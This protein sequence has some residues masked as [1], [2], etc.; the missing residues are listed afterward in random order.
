[1][2]YRVGID[3]GGTFTD[4]ALLKGNEVILHKNLSTPEDRS[5][6]VMEG[7]G[8]LAGKEGLE[9]GQFLGKCEAIVHGTTVADNTLIEM[10]G[11]LT[12]LITTE[13]FR[14]E[15]EY[16][17]GYKED[18]WDVRLA[19]PKQITPRRRRL[20][21]PERILHDGTVH[22]PLDED[23]LR[24]A[25]RKLRLQ[26]VEA[27]AISFLFSFVNPEHERRAKEIVTQEIQNAYISAS[28]E[29][30]PRAPEYDRTSTTVVNAYVGPRVTGYLE[31]LVQR[32]VEG[33][34]QNQLMVM[35]ASGGVMT[36]EYIDG[37]PIRVLA[38]GPAGGVIGSAHTGTAKGCPDLLC[39]DMGGTSYDMSLVVGGQAP[40]EAGWNMHHRYLIG[41]PMVKVETLGAGGG[42][43]CHVNAG[44]LEVGPKSAGSEP[45]PICYGRG[46]TEPTVT[47]ALVM[48]GILST[49]EGFAGGSFSLSKKGVTEAFQ[50]IA[51]EMGHG[52]AEQAAF[53]CWR[54]VNA[55][56]SQG[57]RRTTA[58]KGIDPKDL[59]ML[60][61]GGNGPAFAAIQAEDLG[62][63]RV[64]VPKASPTFSALG[65]LVANPTID[66]ERSYIAS[67]NALDV[68]RIR[69]LW[70][71][72]SNRARKY[73]TDAHFNADQIRVNYQLNMRYPG[74][75]FSLSL[76]YQKDV[77]LGDLSFIGD[78]FG[79]RA[80]ELFNQRHMAEYAHIR[81][82]EVP[83]I[84]GVRLAAHVVTPSPKASGGFNPSGKPP[85]AAKQRRANLGEGFAPVP[86]YLGKD[87]EPG[88]EVPSPSIIEETFTTI[89]VYPGWKAQVDDAGDYQLV[90]G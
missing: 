68:D 73:F 32:L 46:G 70:T 2:T 24:E 71:D 20:T 6:G 57:V 13:G 58:G 54:V 8:K 9:L 11:A 25:C 4:F 80:I 27:V 49:D 45:G 61:Y 44:A 35:Q 7:L 79:A 5:L 39:V 14:D 56:M 47:D 53:D 22:V 41:V 78:D 77:P 59:V 16:R 66:E 85:V 84:S 64:L 83:E 88:M 82:H 43:I 63:T 10:N 33:G 81:E 30:L 48:L 36:K 26:N 89:V 67:A 28:H 15:I 12:G 52:D 17:R 42:S 65:T 72:L 1:M 60:A 38:S 50:T 3:I 55:N 19:P 76:D 86:V 62:I 40:A 34:Y 37:A 69:Q 90:K 51:D 18:I 23:A 75:N 74:Q 31:K 87:L 21:V 29:V